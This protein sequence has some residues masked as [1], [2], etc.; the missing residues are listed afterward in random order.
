MHGSKKV[1]ATKKYVQHIIV[2]INPFSPIQQHARDCYPKGLWHLILSRIYRISVELSLP[3][4]PGIHVEPRGLFTLRR[5]EENEAIKL[6]QPLSRH[7][8][9][10]GDSV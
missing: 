8:I 9:N 1:A 4:Q 5:S 3:R 6:A 7:D 2:D 10:T